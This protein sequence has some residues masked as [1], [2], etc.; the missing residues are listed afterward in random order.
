MALALGLISLPT[1]ATWWPTVEEA[2][3]VVLTRL[4][5]AGLTVRQ[6]LVLL[7]SQAGYA[8]AETAAALKIT[9]STVKAHLS[10]SR[11]ILREISKLD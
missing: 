8:N 11:K 1:A 10:A 3:T 4:V 7:S 2:S 9:T 6:A 5:S